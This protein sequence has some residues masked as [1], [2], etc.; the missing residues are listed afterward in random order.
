MSAETIKKLLVSDDLPCNK[1]HFVISNLDTLRKMST[2]E[3]K[4]WPELN[5]DKHREKLRELFAH[6]VVEDLLL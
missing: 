4:L 6:L 3:L 2:N 1:A 5:Y